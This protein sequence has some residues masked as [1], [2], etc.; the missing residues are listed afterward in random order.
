MSTRH[1]GSGRLVGWI[2]LALIGRCDS[3]SFS[4]DI[5]SRSFLE[6]Q[7]L[8]HTYKGELEHSSFFGADNKHIGVS[9]GHARE[10]ADNLAERTQSCWIRITVAYASFVGVIFTLLALVN[11]RKKEGCRVAFR[12]LEMGDKDKRKYFT[13]VSDDLVDVM[14]L[15]GMSLL[16]M[17]DSAGVS[18]LKL[19]YALPF[20]AIQAWILQGLIL[21]FMARRVVRLAVA[22][23]PDDSEE[24]RDAYNVPFSI[25]FAAIYLH[26]INCVNDLPY[27]LSIASHIGGLHSELSHRL[28]AIPTFAL[29][30]LVVPFTSLVIGALYLC[31]SVS[32]ADVILNSCA[33]AFISNID[34]WILNLN[35]NLN[36]SSGDKDGDS[37][38][39]FVPVNA[40]LVTNMSWWM[41]VIPVVPSAFSGFFAYVGLIVLK[42]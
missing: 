27:S 15:S 34:N 29:D 3:L 18:N 16:N 37:E 11:T 9:H 36:K 12:A 31:T 10:T 25:I 20:V 40:K 5:V 19:L 8:G 28:V 35:D 13:I 14:G 26:F 1:A 21:F 6:I 2:V 17:S 4:G 7:R 23:P 39:V 42:L 30:G 32:V 33:V 22:D 38:S 24:G 41:C